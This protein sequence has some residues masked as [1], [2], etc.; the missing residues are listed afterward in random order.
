MDRQN[1]GR[2]LRGVRRT[3]RALAAFLALGALAT[4]LPF[5]GVAQTL[6][7]A[8]GYALFGYDTTTCG[9][10]SHAQTINGDVVRVCQNAHGVRSQ[11]VGREMTTGFQAVPRLVLAIP[12]KPEVF[13]CCSAGIFGTYSAF[14]FTAP[15]NDPVTG[16]N[17]TTGSI[18]YL[19]SD[20]TNTLASITQ[21]ASVATGETGYDLHYDITNM[22]GGTLQIRPSVVLFDDPPAGG[23]PGWLAT[24]TGPHG[25]TLT[26]N[27][28]GGA[29]T[30]T[31]S[32]AGS[33]PLLSSYT[34]DTHANVNHTINL[35]NA[36]FDNTVHALG[37][38]A[39]PT[40]GLQWADHAT[41][42][43][44]AASGAA[45][46][47]H[48]SLHVAM[49]RLR[50]VDLR[51]HDPHAMLTAGSTVTI[52]TQ[53]FD[54]RPLN[55]RT[56][57]WER[58]RGGPPVSGSTTLDAA[59]NG[60]A[61]FTT[62]ALSGA[63][64]LRVYVDYNNNG[65]RDPDEEEQIAYLFLPAA[66]TPPATPPGGTPTPPPPPPPPP[67]GGAPLTPFSLKLKTIG[68]LSRKSIH[69]SGIRL[70]ATIDRPGKVVWT[71]TI[72][73][74]LARKRHLT[75]HRSTHPF[76]LGTV[77]KTA[78]TP[79]VVTATLRVSRNILK[80]FFA[81]GDHPTLQIV[82]SGPAGLETTKTVH[83]TIT[84]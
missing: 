30:I 38:F 58:L 65:A 28:L 44:L 42:S 8:T 27:P 33:S 68:K 45:A 71:L 6:A 7:D 43:P 66:S 10:G 57:R 35:T 56:L 5:T 69:R 9:L 80:S 32:T 84:G 23:S 50:E 82:V 18:H 46:T 2:R 24:T 36:S 40:V 3:S 14:K 31:E 21:T 34:G 75:K 74:S 25:V 67:P 12:Q 76:V 55:G 48:Y 41:V 11:F 60:T 59:G 13:S 26:P 70:S 64:F 62:A 78:T 19:A 53:A 49:T 72:P 1:P 61:T 4:V 20:G 17:P 81:K 16:T 37:P 39:V 73:N 52:D 77:T 15:T 83:L 47:G 54:D 63:V 29:F 51:L 22:S 79:G